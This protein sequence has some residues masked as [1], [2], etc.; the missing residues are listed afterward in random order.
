MGGRRE[1]KGKGR[2]KGKEER[3][4]RTFDTAALS[5]FDKFLCN[6]LILVNV[7]LHEL[8]L[9]VCGCVDYLVE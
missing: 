3:D 5:M 9:R 6:T 4:R 1:R 8:R 7:Q 2:R